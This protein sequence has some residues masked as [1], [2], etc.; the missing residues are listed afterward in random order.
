MRKPKAAQKLEEMLSPREAAL[1]QR[2]SW[3]RSGCRS[4]IR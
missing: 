3:P 4:G 2:I 1:E